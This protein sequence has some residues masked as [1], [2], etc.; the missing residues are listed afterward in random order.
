MHKNH[1]IGWDAEAPPLFAAVDKYGIGR[2]Q[3][4][5]GDRELRSFGR[6]DPL[7]PPRMNHHSLCT[8]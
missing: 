2:G 6:D 7:C 5:R 1:V 4:Y 3:A 8:L